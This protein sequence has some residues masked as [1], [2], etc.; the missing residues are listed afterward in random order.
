MS[1]GEWGVFKEYDNTVRIYY[2]LDCRQY[3][4][5]M[6][7]RR[8]TDGDGNVHKEYKI[9][10]DRCGKNGTLHWS[11]NLAEH[12]WKAVNPNMNEDY[13]SMSVDDFIRRRKDIVEERQS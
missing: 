3:C 12:S 8:V 7:M 10:C 4:G 13:I 9:V 11:K 1:N 6:R 2:C 5:T